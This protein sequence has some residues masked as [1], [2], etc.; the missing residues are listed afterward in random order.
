MYVYILRA[1]RCDQQIDLAQPSKMRI[2]SRSS[3]S[4]KEVMIDYVW[5]TSRKGM[6]STAKTKRAFLTHI[7]K[8]E[9]ERERAVTGI[10]V[11]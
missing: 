10:A 7:Q 8:I 1:S 4:N 11:C 9:R 3:E 5:Q 6:T 2:L